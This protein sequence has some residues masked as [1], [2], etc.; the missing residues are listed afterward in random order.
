MPWFPPPRPDWVQ[1]TNSNHRSH[2]LD[3]DTILSSTMSEFGDS[4]PAFFE[5][6]KEPFF[7]LINAL[8]NEAKLNPLGCVFTEKY[9]RRLLKERLRILTNNIAGRDPVRNPVF[10]VGAP[11]TG[12]TA[13]FDLFAQIGNVRVGRGWEFLYPT[14]SSEVMEVAEEELSFPQRVSTGL[15]TI[16]GYSAN[17]PKECLSL[18]SFAFKSEEFI[19][20]YH[21]PSYVEWLQA[22]NMRSAYEMHRSVLQMLQNDSETQWVLKSPVHLHSIPVLLD[23]YP[24][25]SFIVTHREPLDVLSSVS[26]LVSALRYAFSDH[27]QPDLIGPYHIDLYARS[28]NLL[29]DHVESGLLPPQRTVHVLH[30]DIIDDSLTVMETCCTAFGIDFNPVELEKKE[31]IAGS[32]FY[33]NPSD[34]GIGKDAG[35]LFERYRHFLRNL[36]VTG[37]SS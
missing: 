36:S 7:V 23:I 2:R 22:T 37:V 4:G 24:D 30:Q 9:L 3:G 29:V 33:D 27:V 15:E 11:R 16:H 26:N 12:T 19:S 6:I 21:V 34:F 31:R 25:A 1:E 20:R 14:H 28:L 35:R 17:M 5:N 32:A 13:L 18:M 10:I 8:N